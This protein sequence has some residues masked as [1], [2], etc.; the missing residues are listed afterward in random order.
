MDAGWKVDPDRPSWPRCCHAEEVE[1]IVVYGD[2]TDALSWVASM[3][4]DALLQAEAAVEWRAV[5]AV[6]TTRVVAAPMG[7]DMARRVHDIRG[8]HHETALPGEPTGWGTPLMVPNAGPPVSAYA[9]AV[10]AGIP[11]HVR[12]LLFRSYWLDRLDIGNPDVLRHLL[13]VPFLHGSS[14]S[15]VI[16]QHG[17]AVAI[18]GGPITTPAW[19]LARRWRHEWE[20]L[21]CP[22]LPTVVD[23]DLTYK[24]LEAADHLGTL[25][26]PHPD[27][28]LATAAANPF[29]LP[30]MPLA[31]QQRSITRPGLRAAW[32]DA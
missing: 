31:A 11:D 20:Q 28:A 22:E 5:R 23:E 9:E 24:G 25:I 21:G 30:P 19:W 6:R 3:R 12:H 8:W 4:V 14:R 15:E 1:M 27:R 29:R 32:W 13:A 2:F 18:G 7:A 17:Y 10:E 26:E 16:S